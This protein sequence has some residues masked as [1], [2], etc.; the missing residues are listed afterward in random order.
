MTADD[1][2]YMV[3]V[4]DPNL[5]AFLSWHKDATRRGV[6][7]GISWYSQLKMCWMAA[8]NSQR[9]PEYA[10]SRDI[11]PPAPSPKPME[12][13]RDALRKQAERRS[14][15]KQPFEPEPYVVDAD[16][17]EKVRLSGPQQAAMDTLYPL[18]VN[19]QT[20]TTWD[21]T[22]VRIQAPETRPMR[23]IPEGFEL[24]ETVNPGDLP[25][26]GPTEAL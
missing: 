11:L 22:P 14:L 8:K 4:D 25:V 7:Q 1:R 21:G 20:P 5:V 6:L 24:V 15:P 16:P 17:F 18:P 9:V 19:M 12:P 10:P 23:V 13:S 26:V 3:D 2:K